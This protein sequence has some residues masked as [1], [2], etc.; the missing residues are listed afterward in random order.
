MASVGARGRRRAVRPRSLSQVCTEVIGCEHFLTRWALLPGITQTATPEA[1][2]FVT[3]ADGMCLM[4]REDRKP[5]SLS[6]FVTQEER[7]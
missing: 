3:L 4:K 7:P 2:E 1:N 6:T 5:F